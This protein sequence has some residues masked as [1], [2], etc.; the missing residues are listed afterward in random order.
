MS[1]QARSLWG[2]AVGLIYLAWNLIAWWITEP[3]EF[4][5]TYRYFG[6]TLFDIQNPGVTPVLLYTTLEDPKLV[7]LAQV[8]LY[9]LAW[10][11]LASVVANRLHGSW[12]S[13]VTG[14]GLLV[15]SMTTPLW[16]WNTYLA[17][18]S[19]S[20]TATTLW[21][22]ALI[23]ARDRFQT[24]GAGVVALVATSA[25]LVI[26]RPAMV[27]VIL[28]TLVV[29]GVWL[30]RRGLRPAAGT[31]TVL[32][33][34]PFAGYALVRLQLLAGNDIYRYRYAIN[35]YVDKTSSF[36]AYADSNMPSCEPLVNAVNGPAPWDEVWVLKEQL[37]STCTDSYLW[38]RSDATSLL[39]WTL[40]SPGNALGNFID[41]MPRVLLQP[42]SAGRAMPDAMSSLLMPDWPAWLL[43]IIYAVAG[44]TLAAVSGARLRITAL[45]LLGAA[46]MAASVFAYFYAVWGADGIELNRHLLPLTAMLA[47][48]LVVLPC[49]LLRR[50][51]ESG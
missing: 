34:L 18:E 43:V 36:R 32:G 28:P 2:W 20:F 11:L 31:W 47:V 16:S 19:L 7:T 8:L 12:L 14:I 30:W 39:D 6:S 38:L 48:A 22:T 23:W 45:W 25:L 5:D 13:P 44:I 37:I 46:T 41:A 42:Y 1:V 24:P 50:P 10:L 40:A 27:A 15:L 4:G 3:Q 21:L 29:F 9:S 51:Q 35:N 49:G 26:T 17:S 33:F